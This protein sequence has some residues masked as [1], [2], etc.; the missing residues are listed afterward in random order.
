M[1]FPTFA[2]SLTRFENTEHIIFRSTS[3]ADLEK[4]DRLEVQVVSSSDLPLQYHRGN[5]EAGS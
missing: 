3:E 4:T 1:K 2:H 5:K